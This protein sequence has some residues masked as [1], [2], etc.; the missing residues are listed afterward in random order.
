MKS[1]LSVISLTLV[2]SGAARSQNL[3]LEPFGDWLK[4]RPRW[5]QS[6]SEIAYIAVRCG[7]LYG[8]IGS[9]FTSSDQKPELRLRGEDTIAR[10]IR[11]T[12]F[13]NELAK[14]VG[15]SKAFSQ[16]R[17]D[18]MIEAYQNAVLQNRSLH[19]N[20]FHGFIQGDFSFCHE[21]ERSIRAAANDASRQQN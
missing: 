7:A 5:S 6:T 3:E 20:I 4:S 21:F 15:I 16:R 12:M 8:V 11:L 19:N 18:L 17:L 1:L 10:G 9:R 14:D 2:L 13:G